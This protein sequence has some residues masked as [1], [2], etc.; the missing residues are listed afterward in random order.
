M[1]GAVA[2]IGKRFGFTLHNGFNSDSLPGP[3]LFC[4][5]DRTY[6]SSLTTALDGEQIDSIVTFTGHGFDFPSDATPV[7]LFK[8]GSFILMPETAWNFNPDTPKMDAEGMAQ[9]AYKEHA[10]GRVVISGEAA[11]FTSQYFGGLSWKKGGMSTPVASSN[12]KLLLNIIHWLDGLY[13]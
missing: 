9:L 3:D 11:M 10:D 1:P 13:D 7:F 8:S 4:R 2:D 6:V 12:Y 5:S